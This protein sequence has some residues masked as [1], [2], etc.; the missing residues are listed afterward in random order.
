MISKIDFL[1]R[2]DQPQ[3]EELS[4]SELDMVVGGWATDAPKK[5]AFVE[6]GDP[7]FEPPPMPAPY[8]DN[9]PY[10]DVPPPFS[11]WT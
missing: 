6:V 2:L 7:I 11:Q 9:L 10:R 5:P 1:R 3:S 8:F 4:D